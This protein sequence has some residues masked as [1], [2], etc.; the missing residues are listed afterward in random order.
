MEQNIYSVY[1]TLFTDQ[2]RDF[3]NKEMEFHMLR[4]SYCPVI[5]HFNKLGKRCASYIILTSERQ[6]VIQHADN[7][8]ILSDV[9]NVF[10]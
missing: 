8:R 7:C 3:V 10:P 5:L 1:V 6:F 2:R 9:I 4:N